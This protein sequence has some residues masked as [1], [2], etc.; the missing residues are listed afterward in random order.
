MPK[1]TATATLWECMYSRTE[2]DHHARLLATFKAT[3]DATCWD[4]PEGLN[5]PI[6]QMNSLFQCHWWRVHACKNPCT[7]QLLLY[8]LQICLPV[9]VSSPG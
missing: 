2:P 7:E 5:N 3:K 4:L 9:N 1:Q 6:A 8:R